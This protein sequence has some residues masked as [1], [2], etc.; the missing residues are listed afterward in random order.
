MSLLLIILLSSSMCPE[1]EKYSTLSQ[2]CKPS[3]RYIKSSSTNKASC[4]W[5]ILLPEKKEIEKENEPI[6]DINSD[7]PEQDGAIVP[8]PAIL[9]LFDIPKYA[10][11]MKKNKTATVHKK[12]L[13]E[14]VDRL[15]RLYLQQL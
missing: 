15:Y 14:L 1:G 13:N 3:L 7:S 6:D 8:A 2:T 4:P 10:A 12:Q 11:V 5:C 9:N